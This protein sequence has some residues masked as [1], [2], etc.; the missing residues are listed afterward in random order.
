MSDRERIEHLMNIYK[1]TPSQFADRTGI[2][3]ASVSHIL[4]DRNKASLEVFLKIHRSFPDVPLDWLVADEGEPPTAD[5]ISENTESGSEVSENEYIEDSPVM[6]STA[7]TLF[8]SFMEE[9]VAPRWESAGFEASRDRKSAKVAKTAPSASDKISAASP[10]DSVKVDI[11]SMPEERRVEE[12]V[13]L[14]IASDDCKRVR[15]IKIFYDNGT[16]E[17]FVPEK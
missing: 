14:R 17:T 16:Y 15:E 3:R 4:A 8:P 6:P 11:P 13:A 10:V 1:L 2:Q 5:I 7:T 12:P 9:V